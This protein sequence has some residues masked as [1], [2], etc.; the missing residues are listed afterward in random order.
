MMWERVLNCRSFVNRD[1]R[2]RWRNAPSSLW[3]TF[4]T[5]AALCAPQWMPAIHL[6]GL[7]EFSLRYS[8]TAAIASC[9]FDPITLERIYLPGH[10]NKF[11]SVCKKRIT[12]TTQ[13]GWKGNERERAISGKHT[14]LACWFRRRAETNFASARTCSEL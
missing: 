3:M 10:E 1:F 7:H 12:K 8:S 2:C 5:P 14:R 6:G 9:Q 13:R 4:F 11:R